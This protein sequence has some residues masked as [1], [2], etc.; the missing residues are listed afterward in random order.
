MFFVILK[1]HSGTVS[2][3]DRKIQFCMGI[4]IISAG[5]FSKNDEGYEDMFILNVSDLDEV[6]SFP[7]TDPVPH[8]KLLAP[9]MYK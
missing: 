3:K 1:T 5:S 8:A 6:K 4:L 7:E 2:E 9:V